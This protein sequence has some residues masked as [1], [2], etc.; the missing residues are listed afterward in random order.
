MLR[1][2]T[3]QDEVAPVKVSNG[4]AAVPDQTCDIKA[5]DIVVAEIICEAPAVEAPEAPALVEEP[6]QLAP[7]IE[8]AHQGSAEEHVEPTQLVE[9]HA[10]PAVPAEEPVAPTM[11][12]EEPA[13]PFMPAEEPATPAAP[14]EEHATPA[15]PIEEHAEP[16][17]EHAEWSSPDS[18]GGKSAG[19]ETD[20]TD[21]PAMAVDEPCSEAMDIAEE[22]VE[23]SNVAEEMQ[24]AME[25]A[26][27]LDVSSV[28]EDEEA[29]NPDELSM[30]EL[31]DAAEPFS[32]EADDH[33]VQEEH[34]PFNIEAEAEE[35]LAAVEVVEMAPA[36]LSV[37]VEEMACAIQTTMFEQPNFEAADMSTTPIA[38]AGAPSVAAT[39]V[40]TDAAKTPKTAN[41]TGNKP[42]RHVGFGS[43][44]VKW[45]TPLPSAAPKTPGY[46]SVTYAG[47]TP[48]S[49]KIEKKVSIATPQHP[50]SA[51]PHH[52]IIRT[53]FPKST[54]KAAQ[55]EE[56]KDDT[57]GA[58]N[59]VGVAD[60][61]SA[62]EVLPCVAASP[63][64]A[65]NNDDE[66]MDV[67]EISTEQPKPVRPAS[68]SNTD[69]YARVSLFVPATSKPV[70]AVQC[71]AP[72]V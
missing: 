58:C 72:L 12:A 14:V 68:A 31:A 11:S 66:M 51:G 54:E 22:A 50:K 16:A 27:N 2:R 17:E 28:A 44:S 34:E 6:A 69:K 33:I 32:Q 49:K 56:E 13:A 36:S 20:V 59:A 3:T 57:Q 53:P 29:P 70:Y 52:A 63:E 38:Q 25:E 26:D 62:A 39:P 37:A 8:F 9:E 30:D 41:K 35:V 10:T 21:A 60:V 1:H 61:P 40:R 47:A 71:T 48:A 24:H 45:S 19:V 43:S 18:T 46:L 65:D 42:Q 23:Q 55:C 15:V 7:V 67:E 64:I 5:A 4:D